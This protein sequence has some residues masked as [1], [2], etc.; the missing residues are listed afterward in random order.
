MERKLWS[1]ILGLGL[2]VSILQIPAYALSVKLAWDTYVQGAD[3][4]IGVHVYRLNATCPIGVPA[5][6]PRLTPT[7]LPITSSDYTD[8]AVT[9]NGI[10]CWYVTA[11][12]A[13]GM[14][15]VPSNTVMFQLRQP[16]KIQNLRGTLQP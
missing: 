6:F 15:S 3:L 13:A 10:Y 9:L 1:S 11:V 4:A 16:D 2:L 7:P 12:D 8:S 5:N 14:E